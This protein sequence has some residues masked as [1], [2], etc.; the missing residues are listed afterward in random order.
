MIWIAPG[1]FMMGSPT[2]ELGRLKLRLDAETQHRVTLTKGYWM[3]KYEVTQ[4]QYKAIMGY[5][6]SIFIGDNLPVEQVSWADAMEF[7]RKLTDKLGDTL[8][9]GYECSLPTEA[10]WE[11]ACRAGTMS[12]LNS[13]KNVTT[14]EKGEKG[15]CYNLDEVGWYW[16]N[17]GMKNWNGGK[18]PLICTHP[19]GQKKPNAWGLYDMH[20]NVC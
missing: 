6:P 18:N 2:N 20:G 9:K 17:G 16:M 1:T 7:C 14:A 15:V 13:G 8:P 4:V 5:N 12:S 3:G 11:Y 10:Q 19:V